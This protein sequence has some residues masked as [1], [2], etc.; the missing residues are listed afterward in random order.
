MKDTDAETSEIPAEYTENAE[1]QNPV[2]N[3]YAALIEQKG[4]IAKRI[5]TIIIVLAII[6][7]GVF[8]YLNREQFNTFEAF[9]EFIK[10]FGYLG[11][12]VLI[13]FQCL[14]VIYGVI[15]GAIGCIAGAGIYG[16]WQGF[17]YNYIGICAGSLL[18]FLLS[19]K[20]G[21]GLMSQIFS[22]KKYN[23]GMRFMNRWN[24][25]FS[26]FL[27]VAICFPWAPDDFLCY[28]SGMT[29]MKFKR[30][31]FI[32]LTAKPW[33]ILMYSLIFGFVAEKVDTIM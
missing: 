32:V 31:L 1:T 9:R 25:N 5:F 3:K 30:F 20:F 17:I 4:Y 13:V 24:K 21:M 29:N 6:G 19:R 16:W 18:V 14:K 12:L 27:W 11:P 23:A 8:Y 26:I 28:I 15:P 22:E 7:G 33:A 2:E 10:G